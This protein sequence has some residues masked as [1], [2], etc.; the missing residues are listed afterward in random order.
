V[1]RNLLAPVILAGVTACGGTGRAT[2]PIVAAGSCSG[3]LAGEPLRSSPGSRACTEPCLTAHAAACTEGEVWKV[4][5]GEKFHAIFGTMRVS[6]MGFTRLEQP[7]RDLFGV[8]GELW[9]ACVPRCGEVQ[10]VCFPFRM[11]VT[12]RIFEGLDDCKITTAPADPWHGHDSVTARFECNLA[13]IEVRAVPALV[14]VRDAMRSGGLL[15]ED[16]P[17]LDLDALVVS[18]THE[19]TTFDFIEEVV[20]E[21]CAAIAAPVRHQRHASLA[22]FEALAGHWK[23]ILAEG[24]TPPSSE[25]SEVMRDVEAKLCAR[26]AEAASPSRSE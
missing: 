18:L 23:E 5:L 22:D 13:T 25:V 3:P 7:G 11:D 21:P 19:G 17:A 6:P 1:S 24:M 10:D 8:D 26:Y 16:D 4:R 20:A 2:D 15:D 14:A 12:V 9:T